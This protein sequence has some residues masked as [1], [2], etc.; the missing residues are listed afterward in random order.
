MNELEVS[1]IV[2]AACAALLAYLGL[3]HI[4]AALYAQPHGGDHHGPAYAIAAPASET[5]AAPEPETPFSDYLAAA[6]ADKGARLFRACA[7]CHSVDQGGRN[8]VGPAL[9]GVVGRDVAS[10]DEFGYS[11]ALQSLEGAW[12]PDALNGFLTKPAAYAPGTS[13]GYSGMRK[14]E[15]RASLI[16]WL[17]SQSDAPVD[18]AAAE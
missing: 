1:K 5:D 14:P 17:N 6:D 9:W 3:T 2:G 7:S 11:G 12:S 18:L 13:M 16:L 8:K 15:D 4:A 10:A